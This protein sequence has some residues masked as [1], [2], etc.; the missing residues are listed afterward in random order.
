MVQRRVYLS[1]IR[2]VKRQSVAAVAAAERIVD[3]RHR[4]R[5]ALADV[6][7]V[8][9]AVVAHCCRRRNDNGDDGQQQQ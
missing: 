1:P 2:V 5:A 3:R 9:V 6:A 4:W 8:V 7:V